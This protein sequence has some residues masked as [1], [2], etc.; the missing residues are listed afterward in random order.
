MSDNF[1]RLLKNPPLVGPE[2]TESLALRPSFPRASLVPAPD[3]SRRQSDEPRFVLHAQAAAVPL[4]PDRG[5]VQD[6][7]T[8]RAHRSDPS[9]TGV[10]AREVLFRCLYEK[11]QQKGGKFGEPHE[12]YA[13]WAVTPV[14]AALAVLR[15]HRSKFDTKPPCF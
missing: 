5:S 15:V 11:T 9:P 13:Q 8:L 4:S 10:A 1:D 3:D 6:R 14:P 12:V 2:F 7:L